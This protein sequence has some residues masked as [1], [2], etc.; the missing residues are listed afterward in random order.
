M[1]DFKDKN[2]E[3]NKKSKYVDNL[4][5]GEVGELV[6]YPGSSGKKDNPYLKFRFGVILM[7]KNQLPEKMN[8]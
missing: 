3:S 5:G 2:W 8:F 6:L 4:F 7:R 1:A